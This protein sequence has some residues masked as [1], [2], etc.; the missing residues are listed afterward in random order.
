MAPTI[1]NGEEWIYRLNAEEIGEI[2]EALAHL[3]SSGRQI[4]DIGKE[5][6]PLDER[7]GGPC[8]CCGPRSRTGSA[9]CSC[10]T[11]R[12]IAYS[13]EEMGLI[14]WGIGAHFGRAVAQNAQGDVLRPCPRHGPGP[15]QRTCTPRG[16]RRPPR[17]CRSTTIPAISSACAA[18]ETARSGGLSAAAASSVAVYNELAVRQL[19][20][21]SVQVLSE[22]F[23][24]DRRGEESAPA[25]S[26][27]HHADLHL[28]PRPDVQ[29]RTTRT[30]INSA[31]R[32]NEVPRLSAAAGVEALDVVDHAVQRPRR[33]AST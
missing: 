20:P 18:L 7:S 30:F 21:T 11:C 13:A 32:F 27:L 26:P 16:Y 31:Q 19:G 9:S 8:G 15:V 14:Y 24:A 25:R 23:Y 29:P 33:S 6:F 17:A 3:K 1:Q 10:A 4:P 28:A 12:A 5:H 2:D 22:P